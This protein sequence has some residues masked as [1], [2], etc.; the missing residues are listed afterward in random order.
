MRFSF[1]KTLFCVI[2]LSQAICSARP[3]HYS[4]IPP[5]VQA[6]RRSDSEAAGGREDV[7]VTNEHT[8]WVKRVPAPTVALSLQPHWGTTWFGQVP[9]PANSGWTGQTIREMAKQAYES[10]IDTRPDKNLVIA[11]LWVTGA[12]V[13][14]GS[15]VQGVGHTTLKTQAPTLAPRLWQ[16]LYGRRLTGASQSS[17]PAL[18]H[19]EDAAMFWYESNRGTAAQPNTYPFG[20]TWMYVYGTRGEYDIPGQREVCTGTDASIEPDCRTVVNLRL[21]IR[22]M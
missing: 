19:A 7:T 3:Y 2:S 5:A 22:L 8:Q 21:D 13:W 9:E 16:A 4:N 15:T 10:R 1:T 12:G 17:T 20:T 18:Y 11:A 14:F 6:L